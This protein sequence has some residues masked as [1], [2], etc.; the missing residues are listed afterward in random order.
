MKRRAFV[1]GAAAAATLGTPLAALSQAA[2]TL[3]YHTFLAPTST[4]WLTMHMPWMDKIERESGGRIR[5]ER[6]PAMQLGGTPANLFDQARDGVADIVWTLPGTTAG[7]FPRVEVFELPFMMNN[8]AATSR[9]YWEYVQT[10]APDE[11]REVHTLVLHVHGPGLIH[12]R[13]REVRTPADLRGMRVR[14]PTRQITR[15]VAALGAIPVGMPLPQIPEALSRGTIDATLIPWEIVPGIRVQ[16][17]VRHH[18]EFPAGQPALYTSAFVIAMNRRRYD[19]LPADL[20]RVIDANSGIEASA[21][22]GA[23]QEGNDPLGRRAAV[24]RGNQIITLSAA[25][26]QE[27]ARLA[28]PIADEWV[29]EITGRGHNGRLLLDTARQLIAR[30][31]RS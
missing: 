21:W 8:A 10:M 6:Y 14:G 1:Q 17:L 12:S 5:F 24:E 19:G 16:E 30:H 29:T 11:F 26:A 31:G 18:T 7:R 23:T 9:A 25:E 13:A 3:R 28:V 4:N 22:W 20:K 2:V 15:M 27:F